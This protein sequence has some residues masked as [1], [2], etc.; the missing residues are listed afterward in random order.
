MEPISTGAVLGS[1]GVSSAAQLGGM[2]FGAGRQQSADRRARKFAREMWE[3]NKEFS[4]K[5]I[6]YRAADMRAAG[7]NP[8]LAVMGSSAGAAQMPT[9]AGSGSGSGGV[10]GGIKLDSVAM[11]EA[12]QRLKINKPTV[13]SATQIDKELKGPFGQAYSRY[14]MLKDAGMDD[15][16]ALG[17]SG[18]EELRSNPEGTKNTAREISSMI[19]NRLK[20]EASSMY[21]Y[22]GAKDTVDWSK[23]LP[24]KTVNYLKKHG[25]TV[26]KKG[27]HFNK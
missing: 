21:R 15:R 9:S 25:I 13:T 27:V 24:G 7:L 6:R 20:G 17:L 1:A 22:T 5:A 2:G 10:S 19:W 11:L 3:K 12:M 26:D 18:L 14:K 8:M 23:K 16:L 4:K